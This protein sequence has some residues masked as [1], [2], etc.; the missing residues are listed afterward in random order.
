MFEALPPQRSRH[1]TLEAGSS[2]RA[3]HRQ[4]DIVLVGKAHDFVGLPATAHQ[5]L[6]VY[7]VQGVRL[8]QLLKL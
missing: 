1:T 7:S 2:V 4:T 8:G 6:G 3:H 5:R